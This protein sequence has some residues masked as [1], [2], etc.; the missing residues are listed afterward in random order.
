[1]SKNKHKKS[2]QAVPVN[3]SNT[4]QN[5][6]DNAKKTG[7][8]LAHHTEQEIHIRRSNMPDEETLTAYARLIPDG[9]NRLMSL[10]EKQAD[11][12]MKL[13]AVAVPAQLK[14]SGRGQIF[15]FILVIIAFFLAGIFL[16]KGCS[17]WGGIIATSTSVSMAIIFGIGKHS[18][19]MNLAKKKPNP[20][21]E[22]QN[23]KQIDKK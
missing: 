12:R 18:S 17:F 9:A 5:T 13:E 20:S 19:K 15:G 16:F 1:M 6:T 4:P 11:H 7:V 8:V 3:Q 2:I 22:V 21:Q 23:A 10:I 14:Q